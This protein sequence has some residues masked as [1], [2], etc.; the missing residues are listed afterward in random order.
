MSDDSP[1]QNALRQGLI[2]NNA[3]HVAAGHAFN[4]QM[5]G[6]APRLSLPSLLRAEALTGST[7][8]RDLNALRPDFHY[9]NPK[10]GY[11]LV[12]DSSGEFQP[13]HAKE[14]SQRIYSKSGEENRDTEWP[15]LWGGQEGRQAFYKPSSSYRPTLP[16]R[17]LIRSND[18]G[19]APE[20]S[21]GIPALK[22]Q[23]QSQGS[24][25][26]DPPSYLAASGN[27]QIIT[28]NIQ[29]GTSTRSGQVLGA[30]GAKATGSTLHNGYI[31]DK[32]LARLGSKNAHIVTI[33]NNSNK[34]LQQVST[35]TTA[36]TA[37]SAT[38]TGPS[39][40]VRSELARRAIQNAGA[41]IKK[42]KSL[43]PPKPEPKK[44]GYCENCRVR[45]D[46]FKVVSVAILHDS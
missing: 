27:S 24:Q 1:S 11:I 28:S 7:Y 4:L 12:E 41:A 37:M 2:V 45:F 46:D 21:Y 8:E 15:T 32:R 44:P 43:A 19:R 33:G 42:L 22:K 16:S 25:V 34:Y 17:E 29:S 20:P 3:A 14:Y 31:V 38:T 13:A 36:T 6:N 18:L 40:S 23:N 5:N 10:N 30:N 35:T 9:F 39:G 26:Q